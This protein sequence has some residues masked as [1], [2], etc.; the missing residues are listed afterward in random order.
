VKDTFRADVVAGLTTAAVVIPKSMAFAAIAGLPL[1]I[2]LYTALVPP[3]VYA[4][5]GTSRPLSVTTTSTIAILVAGALAQVA[6][7]AGSAQLLTVLSSLTLMVG[8]FLVLASVLRLGFLADFISAPVLTGFKAGIA[9]VIV[10]DQLPKMLGIHFPKGTFLQNVV[11]IV[12]HVPETSGITLAL[13]VALLGIIVGLERLWPKS[14]APLL[15]VAISIAMSWLFG[16]E[17]LGVEL[18]GQVRP[19]LP[20]V[21]LPDLS[22]ARALWPAALGIALMSFVETIAAGRA[23]VRP[24]EPLP[25]PNRELLA[26][27][28]ANVAGSVFHMAAGGGT[29]QT[30][31]NHAAGA[32][33]QAA[34]L[35]LAGATLATLLLLAPAVALMPNAALAAVVIATSVGLFKP[36]EFVAIRRVGREEFWWAVTAMVGVVLFGTLSGILVAVALSMLVLFYQANRPPVYVMGR[37]RETGVFEALLPGDTGIETFAGLLIVRVEGQVYFANAHRIGEKLWPLVNEARPR[38]VVVE[39]SAVPNVEYTALT[40]LIEAERKLQ[41]T[42]TTL[43]LA[44]LNPR[45]ATAVSRSPLGSVLGETRIFPTIRRAVDAYLAQP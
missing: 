38:V 43:W 3:L 45:V 7:A 41:E 39:M 34:G 19:G 20:S 40:A 13:A 31:V 9:I 5:L 21:A 11:R 29:S 12:E 32:R 33:T 22:I 6:P 18:V 15:A 23:F 36:S 27:G 28:L 42:G 14:P 8:A 37:R 1:E 4:V 16:L 44:G 24:G 30:A 35:V 17:R 10:V 26:V 2:G 25:T